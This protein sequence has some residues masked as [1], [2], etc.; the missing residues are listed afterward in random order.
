MELHMTE[1][2]YKEVVSVVDG[3]RFGFVGDVEINL[4]DG[5]IRALLIPGRLRL[6]GL[7][8]REEDRRIPWESIR[9]FGEDIILVEEAAQTQKI[10]G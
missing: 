5:R 7:F 4:Q 3:G 6:F 1:L 10:K 2:K 8:G 9:Q